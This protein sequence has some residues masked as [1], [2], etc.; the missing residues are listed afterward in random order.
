[1]GIEYSVTDFETKEIVLRA[2][3]NGDFKNKINA[4]GPDGKLMLAVKC[5]SLFG[6][7]YDVVEAENR[8]IGVLDRNWLPGLLRVT[9]TRS[10]QT[11]QVVKM[12]ASLYEEHSLDL[13]GQAVCLFRKADCFSSSLICL[14]P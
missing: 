1:M 13:N 3:H 12:S 4:Y 7:T 2:L 8:V 10:E 11:A 14:L 5:R 9:D 6:L